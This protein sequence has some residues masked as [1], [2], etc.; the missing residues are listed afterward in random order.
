[1]PSRNSRFVG[2]YDLTI[3]PARVL[4]ATAKIDLRALASIQDEVKAARVRGVPLRKELD[5][6]RLFVIFDDMEIYQDKKIAAMLFTVADVDAADA[7]YR[8]IRSGKIRQFTKGPDEGGAISAHLVLSYRPRPH[9]LRYPLA[10]EDAEGAPRSRILP[11]LEDVFRQTCGIVTAQTE[12][13]PR[14][15]NAVLEM[16]SVHRDKMTDAAGRPISV[17]L[18]RLHPRATLDAHTEEGFFEK[19]R[20]IQF[21]ID[22]NLR[23]KDA[24]KSVLTLRTKQKEQFSSYPLMR[25]RWKR[26][27]NKTQT[28]AV[29]GLAEDLLQRAFTR[30]ELIDDINPG[31][32]SS[33]INI[34]KDFVDRIAEKL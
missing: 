10:L 11:F 29:D 24:I 2:I 7:V 13:G 33:M 8:S 23:V 20:S 5:E 30:M 25:I 27:D 17:E 1:M 4:D 18:V 3:R 9:S 31:M 22:S 26:P 21:G 12:E 14:Q 32:P 16:D 19:R 34:R 15:G 6:G 28:L